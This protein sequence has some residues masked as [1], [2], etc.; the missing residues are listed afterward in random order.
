MATIPSVEKITD[1]T[2]L[3]TGSLT[4]VSQRQHLMS[5]PTN[6]FDIDLSRKNWTQKK[7]DWVLILQAKSRPGA[8]FANRKKDGPAWSC[9]CS[10]KVELTFYIIK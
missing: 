5:I 6:D 8:I 4:F 1:M 9:F 2:Y 10:P 7:I 3:V